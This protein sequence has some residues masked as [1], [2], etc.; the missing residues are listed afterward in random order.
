MNDFGH[1]LQEIMNGTIVILSTL[2]IFAQIPL[3]FFFTFIVCFCIIQ[4]SAGVLAAKKKKS[5]NVL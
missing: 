3:R 5:L 2:E 4:T 1:H